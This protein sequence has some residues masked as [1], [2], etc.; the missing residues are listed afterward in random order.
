MCL[1][2]LGILESRRGRHEA[3]VGYYQEARLLNRE[4][5][6]RRSESYSLGNL[7]STLCELGRFAEAE[8]HLEE[9]LV[10]VRDLGD[11]RME[12]AW[13][14]ALADV[15]RRRGRLEL[16]ERTLALAEAKLLEVADPALLTRLLVTRAH[17]ALDREDRS[18][19]L[20]L[21]SR[22]E[23]IAPRGDRLIGV[24]LDAV[25]ERLG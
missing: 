16:A 19:A 7:A 10:L 13:L 9:A 12:G 17:A 2:N 8:A 21:L 24:E 5:G 15:Y 4:V 6:N 3:A 25:K 23:A 14:G 22:A 1:G 11:V 18:A 20:D